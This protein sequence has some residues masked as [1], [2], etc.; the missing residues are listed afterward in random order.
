[1]NILFNPEIDFDKLLRK[2]NLFT[3]TGSQYIL[4]IIKFLFLYRIIGLE[5]EAVFLG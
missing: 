2:A 1:M 5:K 3:F 4:L